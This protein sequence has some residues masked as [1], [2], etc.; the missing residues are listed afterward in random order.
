MQI[1]DIYE[2]SSWFVEKVH[3][4]Q[5]QNL[6]A[7]CVVHIKKNQPQGLHSI[8]SAIGTPRQNLFNAL[9]KIDSSQL[10]LNQ[11]KCLSHLNV[12]FLMSHNIVNE[13]EVIFDMLSYDSNHVI[14]SLERYVQYLKVA[15]QHFAQL[16][17]HLASVVPPEHLE[18]LDIPVGK[19]LT[20]LT[21]QNDA[22][23]NNLVEFHQWAK[24]WNLI[25]R[26][27]S[28][29]INESPEDFEVVNADR[30]SLLL[31]ILST[32]GA[33]TVIATA[34]KSLTDLAT[35]VIECRIKLKELNS[36]ENVVSDETYNNFM[37]EAKRKLELE[38]DSLIDRVVAKLK[39]DG[40]VKADH[41]DNEL[42]RSIREIYKFN[43][44]GGGIFCLAS[45]DES[46]DSDSVE[47]L[48]QSYAQLQEK[49]E[50]QL[51]TTKDVT[52]PDKAN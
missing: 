15:A 4:T 38:E 45:N 30:G 9:N 28:M 23:I 29:A 8:E 43:S 18:P 49:P 6:V 21:F 47:K 14:V 40:L 2:L 37:E 10:T 13:F 48:N 24:S 42:N 46:F 36:F 50:L 26:G 39:E 22:S 3:K 25:A 51:L 11:R 41:V 16:E 12:G 32:A 33:I 52:N 27:V 19:V 20:R 1:K 7:Q 17:Q 44:S 34:L 35:S 31:D 5:I